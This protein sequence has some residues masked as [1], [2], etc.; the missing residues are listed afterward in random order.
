[1]PSLPSSAPKRDAPR[2]FG[3]HSHTDL[4]YCRAFVS[5]LRARG[6][7]VWY[8]EHNMGGGVLRQAIVR[9]MEARPHF[10]VILSAA[11]VASEWVNRE[12]NAALDLDDEGSLTTL[13]PVIAGRC[14]IPLMLRGYRRL[15]GS[16]GAPIAADEAAVRCVR[17]LIS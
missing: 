12:I 10:V 14:R 5:G 8:D 15:E 17:L 3:S 7:N 4:D 11:A 13:L 16:D 2:V 6:I 1:M 9:E